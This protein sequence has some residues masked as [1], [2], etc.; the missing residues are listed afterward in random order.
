ML[1]LGMIT[2]PR[3][4]IDVQVSISELRNGGFSEP[5]HLFCEP[6][7]PQLEATE[8]LI[9]HRNDNQRGV[10][11]NWLHCL[12]WLC[13]HTT[14]HYVGVVEDDVIFAPCARRVLA[15]GWESIAHFGYLSGYTPRRDAPL[16]QGRTGWVEL[17]R[18]RDTWG[19]LC[20]V[21]M[22]DSAQRLIVHGGFDGEDPM[23]GPTDYVVADFFLQAGIPCFY[24][25][26]S[27][28][29]HVGK[30]STVGHNWY[31]DTLGLAFVPDAELPPPEIHR[32]ATEGQTTQAVQE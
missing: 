9:V 4:G 14:S 27:L 30:V 1:A 17:N 26:P 16:M 12:R 32:R 11:G 28:S 13:E 22:R 21:F 18:G 15:Q 23:R 25:N 24:H 7:T 6:G 29:T 20:M 31:D 8:A 2:S 5:L 19:T 10:I 3:T